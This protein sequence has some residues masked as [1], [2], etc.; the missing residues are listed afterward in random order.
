VLT[1][2]L[3]LVLPRT[4]SGCR[5][6]GSSLCRDCRSLLEGPALGFVRPDPCPPG[7][8][9]LTALAAYGGQVQRLLL[10]HKEK[11]HLQLT[12]PLGRG[13]AVAVLAHGRGP[14]LLCPVPSSPKVVRDR[15]HDHAMRLAT[16][17][18]RALRAHG[19]EARAVRLLVP[20][21]AVADQSGLTHAA[22]AANLQGALRSEG[23]PRTGVVLVDDV[24]TTG[25]T[26]VEAARALATAG[27][28]VL[29]ASVVAATSRRRRSPSRALSLPAGPPEV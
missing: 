17:G 26:L 4:C 7:L 27:H 21:R 8:P 12:A 1:A 9:P 6:S 20:A 5:T 18:A 29:G 13:L 28:Q 10:S 23:P 25:A 14:F 3:D 11:G 16:A 24:V 19:V 15:G 22:R 2:L